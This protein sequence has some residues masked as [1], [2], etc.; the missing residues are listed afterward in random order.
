M[1]GRAFRPHVALLLNITP[2]HLDRYDYNFELY[3]ASKLSISQNQ[4]ESD[5]LVI[6][7]DDPAIRDRMPVSREDGPGLYTFSLE[8]APENTVE[9]RVEGGAYLDKNSLQIH[10][11]NQ[12]EKLMYVDELALR[13]R[14][15]VYNSLA[16]A[17]AARVMEVRSDVVRE[18][19]KTFSGVPH[20][21][22]WSI[23]R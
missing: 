5:A 20:R 8:N 3:A 1:L 22:S 6:N 7:S 23:G 17:V 13:G 19:L 15:N 2:D 10:L 4:K 11:N 14:H 18:S 9:N 21:L 16:A 12:N